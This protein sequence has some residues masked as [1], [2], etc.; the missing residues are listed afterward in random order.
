MLNG[1]LFINLN[2][3]C[4]YFVLFALCSTASLASLYVS[5][6]YPLC[7]TASLAS[8]YVSSYYLHCAQLLLR[9][10]SMYLSIIF[11]V[12][13]CFF[14]LFVCI[15]VLFLLCST[16]SSASLYIS[17]YYFHCAQLLLRPQRVPYRKTGCD[18]LTAYCDLLIS[19]LKPND[20]YSEKDSIFQT[21]RSVCSQSPNGQGSEY[22]C[23]LG[24]QMRDTV[25][26]SN[27]YYLVNFGG[28]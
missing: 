28:S 18:L 24:S 8:P 3:Y 19:F 27:G 22:S 7:S 5:S 4:V 11:T 23:R 1:V 17:S 10:H 16:A 2:S 14:G 25:L 12:L 13:N 20:I 9:P 15:F 6:Y 26:I 21:L